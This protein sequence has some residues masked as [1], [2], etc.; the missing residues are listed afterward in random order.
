MRGFSLGVRVI[1]DNRREGQH[2][3]TRLGMRDP[4]THVLVVLCDCFGCI[5]VWAAIDVRSASPGECVMVH[6]I[7]ACLDKGTDKTIPSGDDEI[8]KI[9]LLRI[10]IALINPPGRLGFIEFLP[11][12]KRIAY[13]VTMGRLFSSTESKFH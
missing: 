1:A 2:L 12:Q 3:F 9:D 11:S 5:R 13:L 10:V 7:I 6:I 4:C 8:D